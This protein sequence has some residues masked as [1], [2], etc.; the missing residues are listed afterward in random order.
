MEARLYFLICILAFTPFL[1]SD[2]SAIIYKVYIDKGGTNCPVDPPTWCIVVHPFVTSGIQVGDSVIWRTNVSDEQ[3][4]VIGDATYFGNVIDGTIDPNSGYTQEFN[5]AGTL[6]YSVYNHPELRG[7]VKVLEP[8]PEPEPTPQPTLEEPAG[9]WKGKIMTTSGKYYKE[10][11]RID[12]SYLSY[13]YLQYGWSVDGVFG[14]DISN[15]GTIKGSGTALILPYKE[16]GQLDTAR[17][18]MW[19]CYSV[20][21][22]PTTVTFQVKGDLRNDGTTSLY[23]TPGNPKD[24]QVT[25]YCTTSNYHKTVQTVGTPFYF[26][27]RIVLDLNKGSKGTI[28][29]P[30]PYQTPAKINW[31]FEITNEGNLPSGNESPSTSTQPKP[32]PTPITVKD[33]PTG[34]KTTTETGG[35]FDPPSPSSLCPS[36][37]NDYLEMYKFASYLSNQKRYAESL[38]CWE[39]LAKGHPSDTAVM[40]SM[41]SA[42]LELG[43]YDEAIFL[44]NKALDRSEQTGK[45]LFILGE[46][47]FAKGN[48]QEALTAFEK[49]QKTFDY[50]GRGIDWLDEALQKTRQKL[51]IP[52]PVITEDKKIFEN[53]PKPTVTDWYDGYALVWA[54]DSPSGG[55]DAK[56]IKIGFK[57][58]DGQISN[59][60]IDC[61]SKTLTVELDGSNMKSMIGEIY[62]I[63]NSKKNPHKAN[64]AAGSMSIS[65][66]GKEVNYQ[67]IKSTSS[68]DNTEFQFLV[69]GG[70]KTLTISN[71]G[72]IP[73][74]LQKTESIVDSTPKVKEKVPGWIKN[75]A[76]WWADG[77]ID[78]N[79]FLQGIQFMIKEKIINIPNLPEQ[80]SETAEEKVPDWIRSN[81][82]WWADGLITDDDFVKGIQYLVEQGVIRV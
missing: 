81:A 63:E 77:Q 31:V 72:L 13:E 76:K 42:N 21:N 10:N 20:D 79:A 9:S 55:K 75:N 12:Y 32:T 38:A 4:R 70:T 44:V 65:V 22:S 49:Y 58:F 3:V 14:F 73:E 69:L 50:G 43:N 2:A 23:L 39:I 11:E 1:F 56:G 62:V 17:R 26:S 59:L 27:E 66:D 46:A 68:S 47:Y 45:G 64:L 54:E 41:A 74:P 51:G 33:T 80:A 35:R 53:C 82:E 61:D 28:T 30:G 18:L 24:L 57:D 36:T 40:V 5:K 34:S 6:E 25:I 7:S 29:T 60:K 48:Y 78:D 71:L 37:S 16:Y 52:E 15:D 8:T 19:K 67:L